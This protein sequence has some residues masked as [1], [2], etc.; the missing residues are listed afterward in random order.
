MP[1]MLQKIPG[2][3]AAVPHSSCEEF[4]ANLTKARR[5]RGRRCHLI[6]P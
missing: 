6:G 3:R 2:S 4:D 1:G 5:K